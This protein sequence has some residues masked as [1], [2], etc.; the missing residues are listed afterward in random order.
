MVSLVATLV[1]LCDIANDVSE[2]AFRTLAFMTDRIRSS[3][4][5]IAQLQSLIDDVRSSAI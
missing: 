3:A 2:A 1:D 4:L 5:I